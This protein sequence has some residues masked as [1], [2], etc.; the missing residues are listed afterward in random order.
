[1][2]LIIRLGGP[3]LFNTYETYNLSSVTHIA[4]VCFGTNI[5]LTFKFQMYLKQG[6]AVRREDLVIA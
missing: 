6:L 1:M 2:G 5:Y 4:L 3:G